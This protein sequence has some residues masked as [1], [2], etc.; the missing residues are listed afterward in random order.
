VMDARSESSWNRP[1]VVAGFTSTPPN[2]ELLQ[3]ADLERRRVGPGQV[4][5]DLGCGAGR[6]AVPLAQ[7]GWR[8]LG[9]DTSLP[10][11]QAARRWASEHRVHHRMHVAVAPMDGLPVR[12]HSC[13]LLVAHGIWN[14]AR[15]QVEFRRALAEAA[16]VAKAGAGL[17]VFTFSRMTL[18]PDARPL[19]GETFVFTQFSG[20]P[21]CFLSAEQLV[22]ELAD[23]SFAPDS[24]VPLTELNRPQPNLLPVQRV[25]VIYEA[26]FRYR[27]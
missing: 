4:V 11:V 16:R 5:L 3:F 18:P 1:E 22:S 27:G 24:S 19:A 26:A 8:V 12:D 23:A 21:Q 2:P 7:Q 20:Q 25:P 6:N 17:F 14:L 15:S 10:M 13:D 9:V